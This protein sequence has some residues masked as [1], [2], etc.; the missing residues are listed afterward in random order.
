MTKLFKIIACAAA[1]LP[2]G[3]LQAKDFGGLN[4]K[5][6]FT[7]VVTNVESVDTS[8]PN[9]DTAPIPKGVPTFRLGQ[10]VKFTV[11]SKGQLMGKG[12]NI[13]FRDSKA[14]SSSTSANIYSTRSILPT[15]PA[16]R[17]RTDARM[18]SKKGMPGTGLLSF[19][20]FTGPAAGPKFIVVTYVFEVK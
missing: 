10:K 9:R 6:T 4:P 17:N 3:Q 1:L 15:A 11:G 16:I 18:Y 14:T 19:G 2:L 13:P 7:L 5:K 20:K 12:F 8:T